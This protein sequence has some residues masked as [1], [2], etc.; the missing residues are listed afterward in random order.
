M[1]LT[2]THPAEKRMARSRVHAVRFAL[3]VLFAMVAP[4]VFAGCVDPPNLCQ[5]GIGAPTADAG[6]D[7]T[8][9]IGDRVVLNGLAST[10]SDGDA[11][12]Y[13]WEQTLGP[14]VA[15][16][17]SNSAIAEFVAPQ[18]DVYEFALTVS[19]ACN[20]DRDT[21]QISIGAI[22]PA[23]C[24][25]ADAGIDTTVNE[26]S[27]VCLNGSASA[28]P[29]GSSLRYDWVQLNGPKLVISE[30]FSAE[31]CIDV[32]GV[33]GNQIV[34]FEL[35]VTNDG[36]CRMADTV[37][38]TVRDLDSSG[39]K[40]DGECASGFS[41]NLETGNC[42]PT[43]RAQACPPGQTCD[44]S[45]GTCVAE[46]N[47]PPIA[48]AG[49]NQ[50]VKSGTTVHLD[51]TSSF[52]PDGEILDYFWTP[53][54]GLVSL[55]DPNSVT[56]TFVAPNVDLLT[57]IIIDLTVTDGKATSAPSSVTIAVLPNSTCAGSLAFS[58]ESFSTGGWYPIGVAIADINLDALP[59]I[60]VANA[61]NY[62]TNEE[63]A[64]NI[65]ILHGDNE[66]TLEPSRTYYI[67]FR[68]NR[69]AVGDLDR[70]GYTDVV[71]S[72][73]GDGTMGI[74]FGTSTGIFDGTRSTTINVGGTPRGVALAD[75]DGNGLIDILV[76]SAPQGKL[77][78]LMNIGSGQFATPRIIEASIDGTEPDSVVF[79]DFNHDS[80]LDAALT[81][82]GYYS[83][84]VS[85]LLG[86][87]DGTFS[88]R[89]EI[90]AGF[91]PYGIATG[92]FD[93]DSNLDLAVA[94]YRGGT[95]SIL[96]GDGLGTFPTKEEV[97]VGSGASGIAAGD[98]DGDG[99]VD[100]AVASS[101]SNTVS[102]LLS[103]GNGSFRS[104]S[105]SAGRNPS[106]LAVGD[107]D[108]DGDLDVAVSNHMED[109]TVTL[110]LN[111]CLP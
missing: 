73:F 69:V 79:G 89:F 70:D 72:N 40:S 19:D 28:D 42:A 31:P 33:N 111:R 23:T 38:I 30:P 85:I 13:L 18:N 25:R 41:C 63:F 103:N 110:L 43:C 105:F 35:A 5:L 76:A 106:H 26:N 45:T 58:T 6:A 80:C 61:S 20:S 82:G 51:G 55:S 11:L 81:Q 60:V 53:K 93:A 87:C 109:G 50:T 98:V 56:P 7:R 39:C 108:N 34:V 8:S 44:V 68:S 84:S 65:S 49:P 17:D 100:I 77:S 96:F 36:N 67:G 95:V 107:L 104:S 10:D 101:E 92:D 12:T 21:V 102:V 59:D 71:T 83:K 90:E 47:Q 54:S 9:S 99:I 46:T 32:P 86:Y 1:F 16:V 74:L 66:A 94:N 3:R 29:N 4:I 88:P 37:A 14:S 2:Q 15:L 57:E 62:Y 22:L 97:E 27:R 75:L 91:N 78:T 52:D 64:T 24:P 48:D